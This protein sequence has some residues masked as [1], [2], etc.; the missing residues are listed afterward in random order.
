MVHHQMGLG[1]LFDFGSLNLLGSHFR[2]LARVHPDML[3]EHQ[4]VGELLVTDGT[5]MQHPHWRFCPMHSHVSFE[6]TFRSEGPTTDFALEGPFAG[7]SAIVHL[8]GT[9]AA[10]NPMTDDTLIGIAQFVFDVVHQLL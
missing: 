5:L 6:I 8:K 1:K 2:R 3:L 10:E 9:F 4:G 7:M